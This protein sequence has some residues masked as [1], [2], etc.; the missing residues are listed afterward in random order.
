[1][2]D[3][4]KYRAAVAA[5]DEV[6]AGMAVGL[7]TGTTVKHFIEELGARVRAGLKITAIATSEQSDRMA[8]EVGIPIVGFEKHKV[9]DV[10][11][12]GADE[13]SPELDLVKGLGGALVREKIV[14]KASRR[15][16]IVV[17]DS[18]LVDHLGTRAP[19]PVEV[20]PI[21]ATLVA[22][23]LRGIG[24][25]PELRLCDGEPFV[26]DNGNHV[27]DWRY[28]PLSEPASLEHQLKSMSGVV[29]SGIFAGL[30]HRVIVAGAEGLRE[31]V[32]PVESR[33]S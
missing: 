31:M 21:A 20:I 3:T 28:G 25:E 15:V 33:L 14:A 12:D 8:R 23:A 29:D 19:I 27:I 9:L 10:T 7:G 4:L 6:A 32:R 30:A 17:D 24:G 26:S 11:V 22:D 2:T 16:V 13:V 5:V 18:K 1:M